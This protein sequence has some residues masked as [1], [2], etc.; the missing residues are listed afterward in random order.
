MVSSGFSISASLP[1]IE[2]RLN[3][4]IV[5]IGPRRMMTADPAELRLPTKP[6]GGA[7]LFIGRLDYLVDL[8]GIGEVFVSA[9][10]SGPRNVLHTTQALQRGCAA[11]LHGRSDGEILK[12]QI[13][14]RTAPRSEQSLKRRNSKQ[15]GEP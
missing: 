8:E 6:D 10:A 3:V 7:M 13:A 2:K 1:R 14:D 12:V 4:G 5:L 15:Q 11:R 9:R